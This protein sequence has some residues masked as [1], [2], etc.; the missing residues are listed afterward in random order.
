MSGI[1]QFVALKNGSLLALGRGGSNFPDPKC[2]WLTRSISHDRGVSWEHGWYEGLWPLGGGKRMVLFRLTE[3]PLILISF[4]GASNVTTASGRVRR[5]SG[6]YAA[7][8]TDE[9]A[10][11][12]IKKPLV[13]E[14]APPRALHSMDKI[15]WTMTNSTAEPRGYTSAR[16]TRDGMIHV[17]SSRL[18][19]HFNLAWL[20]APPPDAPDS[21]KPTPGG[22]PPPPSKGP[23]IPAGAW[24]TRHADWEMRSP[25]AH[26]TIKAVAATIEPRASLSLSAD[27]HL[28]LLNNSSLL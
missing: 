7:M 25:T 13:D 28:N 3:G 17:A 14:R 9:G 21:P 26:R 19:Y 16:Q 20:N 27:I 1:S 2:P 6:L 12:Q 18:S 24:F 11:F 10:T 5:F 23:E 15:A 22:P 8:S 4:T